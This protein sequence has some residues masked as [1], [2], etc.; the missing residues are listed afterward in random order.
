MQARHPGLDLVTLADI[1]HAPTLDEA[2][3]RAA[4]ARLLNTVP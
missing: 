2:P 3:S 1:G 4:I